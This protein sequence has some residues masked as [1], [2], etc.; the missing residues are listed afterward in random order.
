ME[1]MRSRSA[2]ASAAPVDTIP[3]CA[4]SGNPRPAMDT[5]RR[6]A[7]SLRSR[8]IMQISQSLSANQVIARAA[9]APLEALAVDEK[10]FRASPFLSEHAVLETLLAARLV[11]PWPRAVPIRRPEQVAAGAVLAADVV[12]PERH[13]DGVV[14][15][16]DAAPVRQAVAEHAAL[17]ESVAARDQARFLR[18]ALASPG[19]VARRVEQR[20][21]AK[22]NDLRDAEPAGVL[23]QL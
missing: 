11:R 7:T 3:A 17:L 20:A 13:D 22:R 14:G 2:E 16:A 4:G 23:A 1:A 9:R 10:A 18:L 12:G 8:A 15:R 5:T 21:V 19:D 6:L